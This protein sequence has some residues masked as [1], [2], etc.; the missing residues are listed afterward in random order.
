MSKTL[1]AWDL[2]GTLD[3]GNERADT[4]VINTILAEE[5]Y[6][7]RVTVEDVMR[8]PSAWSR[9][10]EK[11]VPE[12]ALLP[13]ERKIIDRAIALSEEMGPKYAQ[14]APSA[15]E[16]L[17]RV[18]KCRDDNIVVSVAKRSLAIKTL[19]AI[20][21]LKYI[22][23]VYSAPEEYIKN[24]PAPH[25]NF[26]NEVPKWKAH[27]VDQ[28]FHKS[29]YGRKVVVGDREAE[30]VAAG[31]LCNASTFLI[32]YGRANYNVKGPLDVVKIIYD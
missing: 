14:S 20:G 25:N 1:F 5:G 13:I 15:A 11:L 19:D 12:M 7:R 32:G 23:E 3:R 26:R 6:L 4:E 18:K 21:L 17:A 24:S 10:F 16:A 9:K 8:T 30:D 28:H 2:N 31:M 22:D 29:N 27:C